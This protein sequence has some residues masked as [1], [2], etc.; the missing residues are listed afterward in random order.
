MRWL[1]VLAGTASVGGSIVLSRSMIADLAQML[2]GRE[3]TSVEVFRSSIV[4][5]GVMESFL[6]GVAGAILVG[7]AVAQWQGSSPALLL[8][9]L[10]DDLLQSPD[11]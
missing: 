4:A 7:K 2:G 5:V 6:L 10:F 3:V 8:L 9:A 1:Y 11:R